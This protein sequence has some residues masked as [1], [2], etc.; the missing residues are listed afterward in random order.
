MPACAAF[1]HCRLEVFRV[2]LRV[3]RQH[4]DKVTP[5]EACGYRAMGRR[6]RIIGIANA[7]LAAVGLAK[8]AFDAWGFHVMVPVL[9]IGPIITHAVRVMQILTMFLLPAQAV[10]GIALLSSY[11]NGVTICNGVFLAESICFVMILLRWN[12][13]V[14][15]LSAVAIQSGLMN[16]GV[17][18]EIVTGYPIVGLLVLNFLAVANGLRSA[19]TP[20]AGQH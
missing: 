4:S 7:V 14:P 5:R 12:L 3:Q 6:T 8:L 1:K 11:R 17:A 13:P 10:A 19:R 2:S 18:I 20:A 9:D 16:L 15:P